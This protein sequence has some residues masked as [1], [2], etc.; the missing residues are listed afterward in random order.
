MT[1]IRINV[2]VELFHHF[3]RGLYRSAQPFQYG[4]KFLLPKKA[5]FW[6]LAS[7]LFFIDPKLCACTEAAETLLQSNAK[8]FKLGPGIRILRHCNAYKNLCQFD[9]RVAHRALPIRLFSRRIGWAEK[10]LCCTLITLGVAGGTLSTVT[11][12]KNI[13]ISRFQLPCYLG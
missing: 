11:A 10:S 13:L 1:F 7:K 2:L 6:S 5:L 8:Y 4:K 12:A 3:H 9:M